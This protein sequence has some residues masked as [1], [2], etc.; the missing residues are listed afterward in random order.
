MESYANC[1]KCGALVKII[2][3]PVESEI[4]EFAKELSRGL[5]L[6]IDNSDRFSAEE[7]CKC[8]KSITVSMTV[9]VM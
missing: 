8:G 3:S 6:G 2:L 7:K 1:P 4:F 5:G 9:T